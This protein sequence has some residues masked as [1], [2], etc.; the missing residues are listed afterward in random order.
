M[1]LADAAS[2]RACH[3][4][5]VFTSHQC[6]IESS[7]SGLGFV[8]ALAGIRRVRCVLP[9]II[10][11]KVW[12]GSEAGSYLRIMDSCITQRTAQGPSRTCDESKEEVE[13]E[14]S[15]HIQLGPLGSF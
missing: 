10:L 5:C 4:R 12:S 11:Q 6:R 7:F 2:Q 13:E 8:L 14:G 15:S 3:M 9:G 1:H